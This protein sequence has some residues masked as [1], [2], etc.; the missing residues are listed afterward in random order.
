[1]NHPNIG[2]I[3]GVERRDDRLFLVL[4]LVRG[5]TLAERFDA[6]VMTLREVLTIFKQIANALEAAHAK[7]IVHRDL[8]PDNVKITPEGLVK[9]ARLR[10]RET[11]CKK[12]GPM[13]R[14]RP[15]PYPRT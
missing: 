2:T 1:M 15:K 13:V 3:F 4:E 6:G 12:S 8:K 14:P 7:E 5:D 10:A 9:V 11:F